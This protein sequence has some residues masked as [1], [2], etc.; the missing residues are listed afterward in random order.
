VDDETASGQHEPSVA[1]T[2]MPVPGVSGV[3]AKRAVWFGYVALLVSLA[4]VWF[5][6][7]ESGDGHLL[8][9]FLWIVVALL[10]TVSM[11]MA[12]LHT[13]DVESRFWGFLGVGGACILA[14]RVYYEVYA[15]TVSAQG[16][17]A[18]S[19]TTVLDVAAIVAF[20]SLLGTL[21]RFRHASMAA[22][23]RFIVD[24]LAA[25]VV[26][27]GALEVWVVGPWLERFGPSELW[28]RGMYS[29]SP[30]VGALVLFGAARV[31]L[32]V[33]FSTWESWERLL[34]ASIASFG[35]GLVLAPLGY[36]DTMWHIAGGDASAAL[37]LVWIT[38][39]YLAVVAAVYRHVDGRRPWRLRPVAVLEPSYGW[40]PSLILPAIEILAVPAFGIAA[41]QATQ[42]G[43]RT[44]R[45]V[46]AGVIALMLA[47]RTLLTVADTDT[48]IAGA[49]IDPLT[50]L[51]S[52]R[53]FQ[54]RLASEVASAARYRE[55]LSL[56]S[57]DIDDFR[58][59][60]ATSGHATGDIALVEVARAV[61]RAVRARDV[62]CRVG[63]DQIAVILP[64]AD[65]TAAFAVALR[66]LSELRVVRE[67]AGGSLT[68]SAGVASF[69]QHASDRDRL[70]RRAEG[71]QY[72][73]KTHGK[74]RVT[75]YDPGVVVAL[76]AEGRI[77]ELRQRADLEA[78][79]ALA[80]AVDARDEATQDHSQNVARHAVALA[81]D[82]G[83][84]DQAV[85]LIEYAGR[86][87]DVGKIGLPDSILR[88]TGPLSPAERARVE[89]HA[90]LGEQI[91]SSTQMREIL[92]WVRHHHER[93]DGTG[94]PD[95]LAGEDIPLGARI[96]ALAN[97]YDA[98]RSV[99]PHRAA[100]SRS[101]ALQEIDLNLG[102]SFDP[103]VGER[104][105][106]V[107]GRR[108]L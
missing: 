24:A 68:A 103:V 36:A 75:V 15:G 95:G 77:R 17:P 25:C 65:S 85:L 79:R 106:G 78:V 47:L 37:D 83:L 1:P 23:G 102:G 60:N 31:I 67:P 70:L 35:V 9:E 90:E 14:A 88:K 81:R 52:H 3:V 49:A 27:A 84:D 43:P 56:I 72:W 13:T 44:E 19:P 63:G 5:L 53:Y 62:V 18:A 64:A 87:H 58:H 94:Y 96:L 91:L 100:L 32:G 69:P 51:Y 101:A 55:S 2:V 34:G 99:R 61:E 28:V 8:A 89:A 50:G 38:G 40:L 86:L 20:L 26:S 48:L 10:G 12:R 21:S 33:R 54:E 66:V 104:F 76:D 4:V 7:G 93:W 105:I 45:L 39:I 92:P 30:I 82:L 71:A 57:L 11:W 29:A 74:D 97:A 46:V 16:P 6:P 98:M 59:V 41:A 107:V 108:Y 42:P 80:A 73:S 22:R